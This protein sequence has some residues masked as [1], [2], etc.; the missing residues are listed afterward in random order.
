TACQAG[1]D[2]SAASSCNIVCNETGACAGLVTCGSGRCDVACNGTG[3][4]RDGIDCSGSC[5]CD[6]DCDGVGSCSTEPM[7]PFAA[8]VQGIDCTDNGGACH[9]CQWRRA[10]L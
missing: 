6:T 7:C 8:C 5:R 9:Q 1:V 2:C 10:A 4:C 3:S